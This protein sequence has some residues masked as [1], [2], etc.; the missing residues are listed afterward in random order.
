MAPGWI[1]RI[2][3]ANVLLLSAADVLHQLR[4]DLDHRHYNAG[5]YFQ[6]HRTCFHARKRRGSVLSFA[7]AWDL[8]IDGTP[9]RSLLCLCSVPSVRSLFS[10]FSFAT[11][12][13]RF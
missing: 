4:T 13:V 3:C 12:G 5:A 11:D 10:K 7:S 9:W 2:G 6:S 1:S 8:P